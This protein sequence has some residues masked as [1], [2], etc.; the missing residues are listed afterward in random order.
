MATRSTIAVDL[1]ECIRAVYCHW[2]GYPDEEGGVG[3][4]L[5]HHYTKLRDIINLL[6]NGN[7]SVLKSTIELS[8]FYKDRGEDSPAQIFKSES[9]WLE[10]ANN[11]GC[12]YS[13]L[14]SENA[15]IV[16]AI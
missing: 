6:D 10:Y 1:P 13:Y 7:L 9:D 3:E 15:W 14:F 8:E 11:C 5:K 12:E 4:T 2:D 16:E